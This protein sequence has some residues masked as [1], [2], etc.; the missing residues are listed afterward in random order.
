MILIFKI[1]CVLWLFMATLS[2]AVGVKS[3]HT[4]ILAF[5]LP[6]GLIA[7]TGILGARIAPLAACFYFIGMVITWIATFALGYSGSLIQVVL[8]TALLAF[9]A[10]ISFLSYDI[11]ELPKEEDQSDTA[12]QTDEEDS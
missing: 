2:V 10:F 9:F 6:L 1:H 4:L 5:A 7:I 8:V 11:D 3:G 12:E